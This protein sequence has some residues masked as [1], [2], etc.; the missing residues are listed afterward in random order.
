MWGGGDQRQRFPASLELSQTLVGGGGAPEDRL[1]GAAGVEMWTSVSPAN[2]SSF[3]HSLTLTLQPQAFLS[4]SPQSP[5]HSFLHAPQ[6]CP[7]QHLCC[8]G[9][10][11][12]IG[13][14]TILSG[15]I[16]FS[17]ELKSRINGD[18]LP[19]FYS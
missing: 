11:S 12:G 1:R 10:K 9:D 19:S 17:Q 5:L 18:G 14:G 4:A 8:L 3:P 16:L 2:L 6:L 7:S 15:P 13:M